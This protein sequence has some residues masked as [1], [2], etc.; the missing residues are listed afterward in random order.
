MR[1]YR[2]HQQR[3]DSMEIAAALVSLARPQ[4]EENWTSVERL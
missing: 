1:N 2:L 4:S 3:I